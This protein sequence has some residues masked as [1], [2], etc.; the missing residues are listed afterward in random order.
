MR[1]RFLRHGSHAALYR[2]RGVQVRVLPKNGYRSVPHGPSD[3]SDHSNRL[4]AN[5]ASAQPFSLAR[6]L[7]SVSDLRWSVLYILT[8]TFQGG[9]SLVSFRLN[10]GQIGERIFDAE[11]ALAL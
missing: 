7:T 11:C 6:F 4:E 10:F 9:S 3:V 2:L 8:G 1:A 5:G